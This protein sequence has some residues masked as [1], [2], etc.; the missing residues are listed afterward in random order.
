[1]PKWI[2]R[3]GCFLVLQKNRKLKMLRNHLLKKKIVILYDPV[4]CK[5]KYVLYLRKMKVIWIRKMCFSVCDVKIHIWK[6]NSIEINSV[7]RWVNFIQTNAKKKNWQNKMEKINI[8]HSSIVTMGRLIHCC[9]LMPRPKYENMPV[10][11][12]WMEFIVPERT[13]LV[14]NTT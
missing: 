10:A 13:Q 1:M 9:V 6:V 12:W 3:R 11:L 8:Y 7:S 4:K 2:C 14:C 5:R